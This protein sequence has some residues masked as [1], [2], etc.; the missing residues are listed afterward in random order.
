M[1]S[2]RHSDS[3]PTVHSEE[4]FDFL[5]EKTPDQVYFKDR[6]GRFLRASRAVAEMF[7]VAAPE[8][9][10]GKTDFDLWSPET[11]R[12]AAADEQRIMETKEPLVGKIERLV[13]PDGRI[14]WDY[15]TKLPLLDSRGEVIGICGINKDFTAMKCMQDALSQ[16][17]DRLKATTAELESKN[18][19]LEADLQMA[20]QIQEALLPRDYPIFPGFGVSGQSALSFA[21]CY[22]PAKEVGGDFFDIFSLSETRAGIL[23]CD[24]VGHSL[25]GALVTSVIRA[26][27]EELRPMMHNAGRFLGALNL[28]LRAVLERV[29]EPF[30]ATA[31][32]MI[33][34]TASKEVSFANAGHPDPLRLRRQAGLVEPLNE[35]QGKSGPALGLFDSAA[36]PTS[37]SSFDNAD[38][39][40]L[41]TD[42]LYD[43][44]SPQGNEFGRSGLISSFLRYKDLPAETFCAAV[45]KDASTFAERSD[46]DDDVCILMVERAGE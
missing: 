12:Q 10:I 5:L 26:L 19:R 31:F 45:M 16:E 34:D 17:R 6:N 28:R 7:G 44:Y 23:I 35:G 36:Y 43:V 15:T 14:S 3:A 9:L 46:F 18:A 25:R 32:Y 13:Y 8:D 42:G 2:P 33:A 37:R 27:L 30:L 20:R 11:A 39:I 29:E 4:F 1:S 24:V 40:V 21:H 22:R 41:F 38:C